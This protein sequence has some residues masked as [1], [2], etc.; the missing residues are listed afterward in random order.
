M[1]QAE[2]SVR[3]IVDCLDRLDRVTASGSHAEVIQAV[4]T[5]REAFRTALQRD[6]NTAAAL[7]AVFDLIR[8]VNAAIDAGR[9]GTMDAAA[10]RDVVAEFDRVLGVVDLRRR[11][12][13]EPPVPVAEIEQL[14][15][16]RKAARQR[17]KKK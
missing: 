7:G 11:E 3:R 6:L 2:E 1:D 9:L 15:G 13:A 12:D 4:A 16:A 10:V 8:E 17:R 5:A 14:I